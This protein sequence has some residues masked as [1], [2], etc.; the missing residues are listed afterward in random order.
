M[1]QNGSHVRI[2]TNEKGRYSETNPNHNP[3]KAGTL[4]Q[5]LKNIALHLELS[6]DD[7]EDRLF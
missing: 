3:L 4:R 6:L 2:Q 7:L 1:S 5:I